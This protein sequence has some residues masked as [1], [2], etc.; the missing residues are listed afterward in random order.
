MEAGQDSFL[1]IVSNI[2]GILIILVMVA[3]VRA[4]GLPPRL[5]NGKIFPTQSL[6]AEL[7]EQVEHFRDKSGTFNNLQAEV[8]E[9]NQEIDHIRGLT[10]ARSRDRA[11]LIALIGALKAEYDLATENLSQAEKE[12]LNLNRQIQELDE[13]LAEMDRTKQWIQESRPQ[14]TVLENLPTPLTK[15]V[16][17][18][19]AHFRLKGGKVQFVPLT[20]LMDKLGSELRGRLETGV[21]Q[22]ELTGT[23]GPIDNYTMQFRV[24]VQTDVPMQTSRGIARGSRVDFAESELVPQNDQ[25]GE[26]LEVSLS[27]NSDFQRCIR[28]LRQD[29]YTVTF[30]V[31]P[32][33]FPMYREL[34]KHLFE[35]GY[36]AAARPL[37]WDDPIGASSAGTKTSA[38]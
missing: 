31:Y 8:A 22:G 18:H 12:S 38:Q 10:A 28:G 30:W 3:A 1:D 36:Q 11:E 24:I 6:Q 5:T 14:A 17:K 33:S 7:R 9:I 35:R 32:D 20:A 27:P 4:K 19:E 15:T 26:T 29:L 37:N 23:V 13:K 21:K 16:E 2:V 25:L 34:K